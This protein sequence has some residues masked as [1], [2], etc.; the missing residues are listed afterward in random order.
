MRRTPCLLALALALGALAAPASASDE[1]PAPAPAADILRGTLQEVVVE[2]PGR[3]SAD[4]E[5]R[6]HLVVD[7]RAVALPDGALPDNRSGDRV[8]VVL[9]RGPGGSA[10]VTRSRTLVRDAAGLRSA[11]AATSPSTPDPARHEVY[12]AVVGPRGAAAPAPDALS[13]ATGLVQQASEYW[14]S[15]TGGRVRFEVAATLPAYTSQFRCGEDVDPQRGTL[16]DSTVLMWN[17]ALNRFDTSFAGTDSAYGVRKHLLVVLPDGAERAGCPFGLGTI[18]ALHAEGNAVLV[19]DSNRSLYAHE[20]GHNLGLNHSNALHCDTADAVPT[21]AR[22]GQTTWPSPRCLGEDYGDL[23][24]VMG[25]SGEHYGEGSLNG[26][27]LDRMGLSASSVAAVT[28]NSTTRVQLVPLSSTGPGTRT[29]V[30][31]EP[32]GGRYYAEYRTASGPD[33]VAGRLAERPQLGLRVLR[34]DPSRRNGSYVLDPTPTGPRYDYAT[35]LP[36]GKTFRSVSGAVSFTLTAASSTGATLTVT[37][38]V[39]PAAVALTVPGRAAAGSAVTASA[40][41]TDAK[42][43]AVPSWPVTLQVKPVG[44]ASWQTAATATTDSAGTAT[45]RYVN[46]LTGSYRAV[47]AARSGAVART[48]RLGT[49]T[50][51]AAPTLTAPKAEVALGTKL[52]LTGS[53]KHVPSRVVHLQ[54]RRGSDDWSTAVRATRDGS[55]FRA[56]FR[57]G[58]RGTWQLRYRASADDEGRYGSGTS[59]VRTVVVR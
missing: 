13:R 16:T 5:V 40:R 45:F 9:R 31:A 3:S 35:A 49:T 53:L 23:L 48:S 39:P 6:R 22:D 14:S 46:G 27:H 19:S 37:R 28:T 36:L 8:E 17:E 50:S 58:A 38:A 25:F 26:V 29:V 32:G 4:P 47:T 56:A 11:A 57:P 1:P 51:S 30:V 24:D 34:E 43:G 15:Q 18:G 2:R 52:A 12:V 59:P 54:V 33:A 20:L 10:S 7:G 21:S 42:G 41:A 44:A 55:T